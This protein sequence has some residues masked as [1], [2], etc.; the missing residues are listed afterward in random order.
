MGEVIDADQGCASCFGLVQHHHAGVDID[1]YGITVRSRNGPRRSCAACER[2]IGGGLGFL[3]SAPNIQDSKA[4]PDFLK[5]VRR[6]DIRVDIEIG[7]GST[8]V[9][10]PS[11]STEPAWPT[12]SAASAVL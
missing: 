2:L 12:S 6:D 1:A 3:A 4:T 8:C 9:E 10:K 7:S 11:C 5:A